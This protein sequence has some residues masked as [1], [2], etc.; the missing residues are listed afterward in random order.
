MKK[1]HI[2]I[3]FHEYELFTMKENETFNKIHNRLTDIVSSLRNLGYE[4]NLENKNWKMI[5]LLSLSW[6]PN[7]VQL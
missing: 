7:E 2:N 1:V 6:Q 5:R 4:I 3:L